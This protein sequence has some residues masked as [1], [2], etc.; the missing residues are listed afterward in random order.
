MTVLLDCRRVHSIEGLA[1]RL[2]G[3]LGWEDCPAAP[4]ALAA[5]LEEDPRDLCLVV[6]GGERLGGVLGPYG[7][8]LLEAL[9]AASRRPGPFRVRLSFGD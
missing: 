8:Q 5:A 7:D 4:E 6:L 9:L 3:Q 2:A 1:G